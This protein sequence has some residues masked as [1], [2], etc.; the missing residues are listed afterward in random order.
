[1]ERG[2][3]PRYKEQDRQEIRESNRQLLLGAAAQEFARKSFHGAN[4]N[5]IAKMAGFAVGT[6]FNY[7][8]NKRELMLALLE[9]TAQAHFAFI[10]G[11]VLQEG[12]PDQR[13]LK[14]FQAG[15]E[16]ISQNLSPAR[17]MV[18]T[19]YGSDDEFKLTLFAAYQPMFEFVAEQILLPGIEQG[20]FRDVNPP[21]MA[22]MLMI[23]YLGT[24]SQISEDG[25]FYLP[26][27]QVADFA[28]HALLKKE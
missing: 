19:I 27:E 6:L 2:M 18:N 24:A 4:T 9:Q 22:N 26:D 23:M 11:T 17:V 13:L 15:F 3:T 14:F 12:E 10:S 5:Q 20:V 28:L 7:F 25:Q 16:F 21:T 8:P 1:M